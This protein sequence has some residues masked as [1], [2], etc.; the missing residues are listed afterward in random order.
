MRVGEGVPKDRSDRRCDVLSAGA[1]GRCG[2][3][4]AWFGGL[5]WACWRSVAGAQECAWGAGDPALVA[6]GGPAPL[7]GEDLVHVRGQQGVNHVGGFGAVEAGVERAP[8]RPRRRQSW[9]GQCD[10]AGGS[11]SAAR[12][13]RGRPGRPPSAAVVPEPDSGMPGRRPDARAAAAGLTPPNLTGSFQ[14][15]AWS[16]GV[17]P[18]DPRALT[19]RVP[20]GDRPAATPGGAGC[21][22]CCGCGVR[23]A[24]VSMLA[25]QCP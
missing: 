25:S 7:D 20:V 22:L 19:L 9:I 21:H 14:R 3:G 24:A 12:L 13:R 17:R 6:V 18:I 8:G 16:P 4:A 23:R 2:P 1:F 5:I 15:D 11:R 10:A